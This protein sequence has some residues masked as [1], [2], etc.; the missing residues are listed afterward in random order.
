MQVFWIEPHAEHG[1]WLPPAEAHHATQVLRHRAGDEL[2][3]IDGAGTFFR[4]RLEAPAGKGFAVTVLTQEA[5]WGE[6]GRRVGLLFAPV[7]TKDRLEVMLEKAVEL[8]ATDLY[9]ALTKRTERRKLNPERLQ[10][11][12]LAATKQCLRSRVPRLHPPH[13]LEAW[14]G[15]AALHQ[16]FPNRWIAHCETTPEQTGNFSTGNHLVAIGPEGDFTP[17]EIAQADA[18]GFRALYLGQNRLRTET[19]A[20]FALSALKLARLS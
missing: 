7:K 4:M 9:P 2:N 10:K 12:L 6:P 3:A 5:E 17:E 18:A 13:D 15:N 11:R 1:W 8:G 16:A 20:I 19:A 14:L